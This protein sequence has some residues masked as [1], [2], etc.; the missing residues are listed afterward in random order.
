MGGRRQRA[1]ESVAMLGLVIACS[2]CL[3]RDAGRVGG[4]ED[5]GLDASAAHDAHGPDLAALCTLD[6]HWYEFCWNCSS[7]YEY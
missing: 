4:T 5:G 2:A 3:S 6:G 1:W 7:P